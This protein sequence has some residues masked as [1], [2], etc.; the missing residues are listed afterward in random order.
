MAV[1]QFGFAEDQQSILKGWIMS[2]YSRILALGISALLIP[3][4]SIADA[5]LKGPYYTS[6]DYGSGQFYSFWQVDFSS[7]VGPDHQNIGYWTDPTGKQNLKFVDLTIRGGANSCIEIETSALSGMDQYQDTRMWW[8]DHDS[9]D[10]W[11]ALDDNGGFDNYSK[12]VL[13]FGASISHIFVRISAYDTRSNNMDFQ[14]AVK[15]TPNSSMEAC[16]PNLVPYFLGGSQKVI[17]EGTRQAESYTSQSGTTGVSGGTG[18]YRDFGGNGSY[19]EWNNINGG[20]GGS[21]SINFN[22]ANAGTDIRRCKLY[23]NGIYMGEKTVPN[24]GGWNTWQL[25][26]WNV[27]LA[28]GNNVI[29]LVQSTT[30]GPN[31]DDMRIYENN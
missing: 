20:T 8:T 11:Q 22:V 7:Q 9:H 27:H 12:S 16:N 17:P 28:P 3:K 10:Y 25:W 26:G 2:F 31:V 4:F 23:L 29:R 6:P 13:F 15:E 18:I 24:T 19:L 1:I 14:I 5:P 21:A 30:G